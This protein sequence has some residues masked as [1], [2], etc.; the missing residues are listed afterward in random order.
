MY[1]LTRELE[2]VSR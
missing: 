1:K 2:A